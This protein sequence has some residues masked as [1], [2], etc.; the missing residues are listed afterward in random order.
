VLSESAFATLVD[1]LGGI[2][3]D[4]DTSVLRATRGGGSTV[5]VPSGDAQHLN[6][7]GATAYATYQRDGEIQQLAR[8]QQVLEGILARVRTQGSLT[9]LVRSLSQGSRLTQPVADVSALAA[10]LASDDATTDVD[11]RTLDVTAV[12][13]GGPAAYT[14]NRPVAH[15][16]VVA[17][18]KAS[19][20][21]GLAQGSA[22]VRVLNGVG[23]PQLGLS[24]RQKLISHGYFFT[25]GGNDPGFPY[26]HKPSV[27]AVANG[28]TAALNQ[29]YAVAS[30]LGL[31]S[32]DV[33]INSRSQ[34]V[35]D[36]LVVLGR[37][38]R[39]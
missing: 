9:T 18:L 26:R 13:A 11:Y 10:G 25:D 27:V 1:R 33:Q 5:V 24:T 21:K 31:P 8:L 39:P 36:V 3:A 6:G 34:G 19:I 12:N 7:A 32:S 16:F 37:D 4:V 22:T 20:P 14:L 35:A 23:T 2:Q 15:A 30:A 38:Y 28:G 17:D 29:G